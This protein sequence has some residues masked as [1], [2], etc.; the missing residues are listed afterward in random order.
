MY[1][2]RA[3]RAATETTLNNL[4]K[5]KD[6]SLLVL[7]KGLVALGV[8]LNAR[9]RHPTE[10]W[11][12]Q[13]SVSAPEIETA[14]AQRRSF[15]EFSSSG[16]SASFSYYYDVDEYFNE[17][18]EGYL[19]R[20]PIL[21][22]LIDKL[23]A[24]Y[25]LEYLGRP[26]RPKA[27]LTRAKNRK[28][29]NDRRGRKRDAIIKAAF[30]FIKERGPQD[31]T[32]SSCFTVNSKILIKPTA[33]MIVNLWSKFEHGTELKDLLPIKKPTESTVRAVLSSLKK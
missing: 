1:F 4:A 30:K 10:K 19:V 11:W 31:K 12:I 32:Y 13:R 5:S 24:D 16:S 3:V 29:L 27:S 14:L 8:D 26:T 22:L 17:P 2:H 6:L 7:L 28:K 21:E 20:V 15:I 18:E 9:F 33:A 25:L 23:S